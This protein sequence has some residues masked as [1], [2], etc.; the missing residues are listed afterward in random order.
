MGGAV[1]P[2]PPSPLARQPPSACSIG[3]QRLPLCAESSASKPLQAAL[4]RHINKS[5]EGGPSRQSL[6]RGREGGAA[7][8]ETPLPGPPQPQPAPPRLLP[9]WFQPSWPR[10]FLTRPSLSSSPASL[11]S[12]PFPGPSHPLAS[13]TGRLPAATAPGSEVAVKGQAAWQGGRSALPT[14]GLACRPPVGPSTAAPRFYITVP[15]RGWGR[16]AG[17]PVTG[18]RQ[19]AARAPPDSVLVPA[20]APCRPGPESRRCRLLGQRPSS[21]PRPARPLA[22]APAGSGRRAAD[23]TCGCGGGSGAESGSTAGAAAPLHAAS[24]LFC[25]CPS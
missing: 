2:P 18:R 1:T 20:P 10:P 14:P 8:P 11:A 16:G 12:P 6:G 23:L 24:G 13:L 9:A 3:W 21:A 25:L 15:G 5:R 7:T 22:Q 17:V 4:R 19:P